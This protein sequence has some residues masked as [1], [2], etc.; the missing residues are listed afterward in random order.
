MNG[1]HE[2]FSSFQEF[3][4]H[5]IGIDIYNT[6][7]TQLNQ[8]TLLCNHLTKNVCTM[9]VCGINPIW[10]WYCYKVVAE[11]NKYIYVLPVVKSVGINVV[12]ALHKS[13]KKQKR[14]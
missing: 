6:S 10:W 4:T 13:T 12:T 14:K 1:Y 5:T 8:M 2:M 9:N 7:A 3:F 11:V